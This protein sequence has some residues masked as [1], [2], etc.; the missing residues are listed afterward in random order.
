MNKRRLVGLIQNNKNEQDSFKQFNNYIL[1][2]GFFY[3]NS[4]ENIDFWLAELGNNKG[5]DGKYKNDVI[6]QIDG[7][8]ENLDEIALNFNIKY[9]NQNDLLKKLY[10]Q[11]G[12]ELERYLLGNFV[13]VIFDNNSFKLHII[14]DHYGTKPIYYFFDSDKLI[15]G[16][17]IKFIKAVCKKTFFTKFNKNSELSLSI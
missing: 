7:L 1:E 9:D 16:S 14:R 13:I 5:F 12:I 10:D 3:K 11:I 15:F 8:I 6:V 4:L 2:S 17:E